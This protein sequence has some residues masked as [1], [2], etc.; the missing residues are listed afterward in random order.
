MTWH[1]P[2][3]YEVQQMLSL[4]LKFD[5]K[6]ATSFPRVYYMYASTLLLDW[7]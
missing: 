7:M 1:I 5:R 6:D 2:R 3:I 4:L